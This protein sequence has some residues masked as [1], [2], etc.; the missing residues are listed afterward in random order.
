[1]KSAAKKRIADLM[2]A[3]SESCADAL[4][5][6]KVFVPDPYIS[7]RLAGES[8][9]VV[10]ALEYA[11]VSEESAYDEVILLESV[12]ECMV[13]T[14]DKSICEVLAFLR[15][16]LKIDGFRVAGDFPIW[17]GDALRKKRISVEVVS[18]GLFEERTIKT[19]EELTFIE[20][21][22]AASAAGIQT[23]F[24]MLSATKVKHGKLFYKNKPL[25]SEWLRQ[26]VDISC[27]RRGAVASHTIVA[28]GDQA[29]DPHCGGFGQ[30]YA[31]ELII[32]DVFPRVQR[33]GYHGDMTR[34]FLKGTPSPEQEKIVATVMKAQSLALE[35]VKAGISGKTV[36]QTVD[37]YFKKTGFRTE[38]T[39]DGFIG[40]FHGTG[41]GLGLEVHE[42]PRVSRVDQ[43][44]RKGHVVTIEPGLYY[45][46]VGACRIEDVV[47]VEKGGYRLLSDFQ[48]NKWVV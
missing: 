19:D 43:R 25:T 22:N 38:K 31:N 37:Q 23:A 9:A 40:F 17:L 21:G 41:H 15:K 39:A 8:Y 7:F 13:G 12:M 3:S 28:G 27:L 35:K 5:L 16:D 24:D 33:H 26:E 47:A 36:H 29:C 34:T 20:E 14:G 44:L 30:L 11:R 42:S 45:P 6:G 46:G 1:M 18:D 4:Y 2:Y 10:N 48:K 32:I